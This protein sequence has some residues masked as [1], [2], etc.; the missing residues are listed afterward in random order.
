MQND[1]NTKRTFIIEGDNMHAIYARVSTEEQAKSGYSLADQVRSDR[2]KLYSLGAQ[3]D[4]I[5]E[6]VD[7][8][9]SGEFLDRPALTRLRED[10][11]K[12]IITGYISILD[13]D[14]LSRNLTNT[15]LL[16]DEIEKADIS[17]VFVT[18]DY[19]ASPEGKLFFSIRGAVAAFEKAKTRERTMRGKRSKALSGKIVAHRPKYGYDW[20]KDTCLYTINE[21]EAQIVKEI[22][23]MCI[24][25]KLG[26]HNITKVLNDKGL[27][28]KHGNPFKFKYI[29]HIL[30]DETYTGTFYEFREQWRKTGQ[31]SYDKITNPKEDWVGISVPPII[32]KEDQLRAKR[33]LELNQDFA[34]R[35][36]RQDYM[37]TGII[38]CGVCDKG[39]V[40]VPTRGIK[41][42]MCH[43]KRALK[44]C[45]DTAYVRVDEIEPAVWD[46]LTEIAEGKQS[47]AS[48]ST[49][50]VDKT[51]EIKKLTLQEAELKKNKENITSLVLENLI[52]ADK[53]R[54]KLQQLT[55]DIT[56][57]SNNL[58]ELRLIQETAKKQLP[59]I[60]LSD[61]T[62]A[63]TTR[64]KNQLLKHWGLKVI[65]Y[66]LKRGETSF[67]LSF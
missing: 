53:A 24:I 65:V 25:K 7:D 31:R 4:E 32:T 33:Q 45:P 61:M 10:I 44:I 66:K 11:R 29:W 3:A 6:Y 64:E 21:F 55:K 43:G 63:T 35:N 13:P 37:L 51:S 57:I 42:Y 19:D 62:Q 8:G 50:T 38:K 67:R 56:E 5:I 28:N 2:S 30:T 46:A 26:L 12:G 54:K 1:N 9:Y 60:K 47:I 52:D 40:G 58:A 17:L 27:K 20:D 15:L 23:D 59:I 36:S 48:F 14:R 49:E 41:Y 22:Y 18:A 34:R 39:L 16:S